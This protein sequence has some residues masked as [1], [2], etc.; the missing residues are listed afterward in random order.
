[1]PIQA[2]KQ[3]VDYPDRFT[4]CQMAIEDAVLQLVG[5]AQLA[6]WNRAEVLAA[7]IEVAD[8]TSLALDENERLDVEI[9]LKK[10][11]GGD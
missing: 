9:H 7:I 6:G 8:N 3:P 10:F 2:P 11:L 1:M 5:E 4:D